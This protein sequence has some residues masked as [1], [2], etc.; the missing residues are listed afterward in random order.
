MSASLRRGIGAIFTTGVALVG[1][2]AVVANP[3]SAPPSDVRVPA[4]KLSVGS[5]TSSAAHD[6]AL[7][8]AIAHN[9][10]QSSPA[11][12]FK[13]SVAGVVTNITL[14]GGW[15]VGDAFW[16]EP[17]TAATSGRTLSARPQAPRV[18]VADL[19]GGQPAA[20]GPDP[21]TEGPALQHAVTTVA[22][23]V[24]YISVQV[25]ETS[26]AAGTLAAAEPRRIATTLTTLARGGVDSAITSALQAAAAPLGPPSMVV[27]AIRTEVRKRLAELADIVRRSE[28]RPRMAGPVAR[29]PQV[30]HS[31]SLRATL[32]HRRGS[33]VNS[34]SSAPAG[35]TGKADSGS[36]KPSAINGA[37]DLSD[38]N[39]AVPQKRVSQSQMRQ[40]ALA[41]VNRTRDSLQRLGGVL[42][43]VVTPHPL[44]RPHRAH[45]R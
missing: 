12:L 16:S 26:E 31:T 2:T 24:G 8:D 42:R 41:S 22:D 3:V 25:V 21:D 7:L 15:A 27:K 19:L 23:Y 10:G 43:Q 14:F 34:K 20:N 45:R 33:A 29:P 28:H 39:K 18:A 40:R 44:H 30:E 13:R 1:A 38:G 35:P 5:T 6:R 9:P 11:N 17:T 32:G 36:R 4:V 37:T